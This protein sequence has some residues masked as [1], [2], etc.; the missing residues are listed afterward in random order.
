MCSATALTFSGARLQSTG[1][2][3]LAPEPAREIGLTSG[4]PRHPS[5][6]GGNDL[7]HPVVDGVAEAVPR[8]LIIA[9]LGDIL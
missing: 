6:G 1:G 4:P 7:Q 5:R 9:P 3:L 2:K 8:T